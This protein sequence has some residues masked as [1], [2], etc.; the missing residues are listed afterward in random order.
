MLFI[1][2]GQYVVITPLSGKPF[3]LGHKEATVFAASALCQA[4]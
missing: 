3:H 1:E 2:N 4:S